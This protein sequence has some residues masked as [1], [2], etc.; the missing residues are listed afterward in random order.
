MLGVL[1]AFSCTRFVQSCSQALDPL[2]N[3]HEAPGRPEGIH[4]PWPRCC[5]CSQQPPARRH[6]SRVGWGDSTP[7]QCSS[8]GS[9]LQGE[10]G[11]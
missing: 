7:P 2:S 1:S 6:C 8:C 9:A 10:G 3:K 4:L 5:C 11:I